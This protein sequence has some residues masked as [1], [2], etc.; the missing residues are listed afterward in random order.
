MIIR[1]TLV[2]CICCQFFF[3]KKKKQF[4]VLHYLLYMIDLTPRYF[5]WASHES[6]VFWQSILSGAS[7][8]IYFRSHLIDRASCKRKIIHAPLFLKCLVTFETDEEN[9][10]KHMFSN[11]RCYHLEFIPLLN[12]R[13]STPSRWRSISPV[14]I[15]VPPGFQTGD[16]RSRI[17]SL[18]TDY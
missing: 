14:A 17:T 7:S 9:H 11:I 2:I 15:N 10:L 6:K 4:K 16:S 13:P 1:V 8:T 3:I 5:S 18:Q 12:E